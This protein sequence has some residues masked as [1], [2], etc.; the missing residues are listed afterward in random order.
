M[1][2]KMRSYHYKELLK[3]FAIN[4]RSEEFQGTRHSLLSL[5]FLPSAVALVF[6]VANPFSIFKSIMVYSSVCG[7]LGCFFVSLKEEL[8]V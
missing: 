3:V 6:N 4:V 8:A 1:I 5:V 2:L 7:S